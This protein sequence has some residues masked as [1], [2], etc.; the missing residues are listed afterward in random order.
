[1]VTDK[2]IIKTKKAIKNAFMNLM[3]EKDISKISVSDISSA[4]L[5]NRST[6]YL[7]YNDVNSVMTEIEAEIADMLSESMKNFDPEDPKTSTYNL[8]SAIATTLDQT[9]T[10][11]KFILYSTNSNYVREKLKEVYIENALNAMK[12][13]GIKIDE[14]KARY[15]ISFI[16]SGAIDT[17]IKWSNSDKQPFSLDE[18]CKEIGY[19]VEI[20]I[21]NLKKN[22]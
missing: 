15:S 6:F 3:L 4:A 7:H 5:I 12:T 8:F 17:Y 10:L 2:R 14:S 19:L 9:D 16:A 21:N 20:L 11:N 13:A 1:M 18:F 22:S